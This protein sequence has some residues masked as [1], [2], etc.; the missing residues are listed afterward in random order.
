MKK[1]KKFYKSRVFEDRDNYTL[2]GEIVH[3]GLKSDIE[4]VLQAYWNKTHK[5]IRK[6]EYHQIIINIFD[7]IF[8]RID[9]F[10]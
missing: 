5:S 1:E 7:E 3:D 4:D 10:S 9:E 2:Y 8:Y 6:E